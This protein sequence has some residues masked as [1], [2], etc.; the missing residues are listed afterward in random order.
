MSQ[1]ISVFSTI[2]FRLTAL[3]AGLL[4][5]TL[6]AT[7]VYVLYAVQ[8]AARGTVDNELRARLSALGS[9]VSSPGA[10]GDDSLSE[11]IEDGSAS[12]SLGAWVQV[13]D[14]GGRWI[15]RSEAMTRLNI[16]P[17]SREGLTPKGRAHTVLVNGRQI[18]VL[19]APLSSNVVQIAMPMNEFQ[20]MF[21]ELIWALGLATPVLFA[22]ACLGG[23][24][25][26]GR[27]LSPVD[28]IGRTVEQ[29]SSTNLGERLAVGGS[30]DELDRLA[31]VLNQ[32]L[33]RLESAFRLVT[34][35]TADA[36]HELRTPIAIIRTTAE[37]V[38]STKRSAE[39]HE[40]AW[41]KVI[42]QAERMSNLIDDLLLLA[43][44]DAGRFEFESGSV[45]LAE[46]LRSCGAEL[47]IVA[48]RSGVALSIATPQNCL[49]SGDEAALRR[50]FL[51]LLDNAIKYTGS[52]GQVSMCLKVMPDGKTTVEVCDSGIGIGLDYLPHIFD[53]F[54]RVSTDRSRSTG[55]AGLGLSIAQ[56]IAARHGGTIA[57]ESELGVGSTFQVTF[58]K[59]SDA[60]AHRRF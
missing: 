49:I 24:W 50:L 10:E 36:S 20:E 8:D 34:Q 26:S 43:R 39:E 2:R 9:L 22:M 38:R 45:D 14:A 27:A 13:S 18:R 16:P 48:E 1:G 31:Q 59:R 7:G 33:G 47:G 56:W 17:A 60:H 35:L 58:L 3:Y 55:G 23:Y 41:D 12:G 40:A 28:R 11:I 46:T 15:Y 37:V 5:L 19:S 53:R 25:L 32:M 54:Y 21:Q 4:A 29:I 44:A 42:I 51:I 6:A 52:G 30:G 57:V